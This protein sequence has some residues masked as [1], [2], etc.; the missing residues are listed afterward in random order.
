MSKTYQVPFVQTFKFAQIQSTGTENATKTS[1]VEVVQLLECTAAE[2]TKIAEITATVSVVGAINCIALI[3]VEHDG[4]TL[5][6]KELVLSATG[7]T[8]VANAT[9]SWIEDDLILP[10]GAKILISCTTTAV[11]NVQ[12]KYGE[13]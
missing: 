11:V 12:C 9:A 8:V 13:Y 7:S 4:L 5:L 10:N 3:F 6:A 1:N 2:G